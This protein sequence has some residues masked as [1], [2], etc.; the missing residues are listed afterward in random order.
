M[1]QV[2]PYRCPVVDVFTTEP[3]N[4]ISNAAGT[5]FVSEQ[6][7]KTARRI[8]GFDLRRSP[9]HLVLQ[10]CFGLLISP[11]MNSF[12]PE[13]LP[14]TTRKPERS[15]RST[16]EYAAILASFLRQLRL[17]LG[18]LAAECNSRRVG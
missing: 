15:V 5:R 13:R 7:T 18:F 8:I 3:F 16:S 12:G 4:F 2:K 6:E 17:G 14:R 1:A 9:A 10:R 11:H